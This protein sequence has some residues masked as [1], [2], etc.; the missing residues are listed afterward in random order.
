MPRHEQVSPDEDPNPPS[1][2]STGAPP[3]T[4]AP[5]RASSPVV[6]PTAPPPGAYEPSP[7]IVYAPDP[8]EAEPAMRAAPV[9]GG[10]GGSSSPSATVQ[11]Q[12]APTGDSTSSILFAVASF[13]L[14]GLGQVLAG[15]VLKGAVFL[16][17]FFF[18]CSGL[19]LVSVAAA[20]DAY[21]T[22]ERKRRGETVGDW[23]F[24]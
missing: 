16:G 23:Q 11:T 5:S 8:E 21:L 15:Q 6:A 24:F 22:G 18:T 17:L 2:M 13:F 4:P 9:A 1:P 19:G 7:T 14:P 10:H 3:P 20:A 12:P